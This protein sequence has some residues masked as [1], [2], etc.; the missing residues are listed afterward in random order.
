[1]AERSWRGHWWI[2]GDD[3]TVMPGTLYCA[4]DGRLRLELVG[5]FDTTIRKPLPEGGGYTVGLESRDFPLMLGRSGNDLF[6]LINTHATRSRGVGFFD[7]DHTMQDL[8]P[9]QV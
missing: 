8:A 1:M 6:T 7:G 2:P 9:T 5:G 4:D 3:E